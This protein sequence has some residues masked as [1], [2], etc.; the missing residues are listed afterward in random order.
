MKNTSISVRI[1]SQLKEQ[2]EIVL[3]QFGLNMTTVINMLF[4]QIVR[5]QEI[6]LSLSLKHH[7]SAIEELNI[8]VAE[9]QAGYSGQTVG[10]VADNMERIISEAEINAENV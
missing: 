8:A 6:P 4:H 7:N 2:T 1:D 5:E 10:D 3:E 9:R